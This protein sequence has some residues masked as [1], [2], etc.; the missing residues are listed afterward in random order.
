MNVKERLIRLIQEHDTQP[1][2]RRDLIRTFDIS[3]RAQAE[4]EL[5]SLIATGYVN[6]TGLGRRGSPARVVTSPTWPYNKCP[7]CGQNK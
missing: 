7:L 6:S 2:L 5:S 1:I 3:R 4:K